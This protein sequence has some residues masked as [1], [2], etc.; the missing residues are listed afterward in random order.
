[1]PLPL[2]AVPR[3]LRSVLLLSA[4]L[5]LAGPGCDGSVGP[6]DD[7]A[8]P[9]AVE[10]NLAHLDALG[11]DVEVG[12]T[13]YRIVHI[14][15][16]APDYA[17]VADDDEGAA[18]VDDV[19]RAAVVYLRH[20]E[21][22]GDE[23]A[24]A[25]AERLL[26]FVMYMQ[27]EEGL[28]YNF[29]WDRTLAINRQHVNSRADAFEWWAARGV[30]A[31]GEGARVLKSVNPAFA[32]ALVRRVQRTYPH[33]DRLLARYGETSQENGRTVPEWLVY[34]SAAD[35]TSELLL[36]LTALH[37]AYPDAE[38]RTRID[39][40]AEGI[41]R[42]RYGSMTTFPY[43]AH[44]S[45][46]E[47]WHGWG[48]AQTMALVAAGR[49]A[50]AVAEATSFYPRLL[51]D[52]W[53]HSIPFDDPEA[54]R[55]F[56]QIAYAVRGVAVGLV[57]LYE[58]TGEARYAVLAGVAASWFTGNNVAGA[59]MYDAATGRGYDGIS[60]P[61]S[62][63]RNAGAESTIEALFTI[64]E[65]NRHPAARA[66]LA[67]RGEAPVSLERDGVRYRYRV[68]TAGSGDAARRVAV[69]MNLTAERLDVLEGAALD[70]FL[71]G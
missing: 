66:W 44:A 19:A 60:G 67:A 58:T 64:L 53:L 42:M 65:V 48:N 20:Y 36:G 4:T 71:A 62:V 69:V 68:F 21:T 7:A 9:A 1:M 32:E 54:T 29:V 3:R 16:E 40:F 27:T 70:R 51:V 11:E 55:T 35:A 2:P 38:L 26:R 43:G 56:E 39:R 25:R 12:G 41:E 57:R 24:R 59:V 10:V 18:C 23:S 47:G 33:L 52:G 13:P 50:S 31:M 17:W 49:P 8:P 6:D 15:A 63:N 5:L 22:T 34:G 46:R 45:W 61:S 14:Y 30:W 37:A 28:F